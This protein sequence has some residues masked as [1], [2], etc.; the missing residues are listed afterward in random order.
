MKWLAAALAVVLV[1]LQYRLWVSEDGVRRWSAS[2]RRWPRSRP[3]TP[4]LAERNRQLAAEVR[5]LKTGMDALEERARSDLG[6]IARNE[7]FYQVV[8]AAPGRR[9]AADAD[10]GSLTRSAAAPAPWHR[11][12]SLRA[13]PMSIGSS[14]PPRAAAAASATAMPKQYAPLAGRTVIEWALAPFLADPR[15][16]RRRGGARGRIE[17]AAHRR[18]AGGA[19]LSRPRRR[20]ASAATRCAAGSPRST[21]ALQR[22]DWV[23]VHDAARPC[24]Q[25]A[26]LEQLLRRVADSRRR[27]PARGA[28][29]RHPQARR[30]PLRRAQAR[31]RTHASTGRSVAGADPADVP[32]RRAVRGARCSARAGRYAH[33]RGA[34]AR[35]ARRAAAAGRGLGRQ[36]QDHHARRTSRS[37]RGCSALAD[38]LAMRIGSG[39]DVHAFGPGDSDARRRA[40]PAQPRRRRAFGRRRGAARAVRC[41]A[42]RRRPRRHRPALSRHRPA[43]EGRRQPALRAPRARAAARARHLRVVNADLTVL[44]EAPR[45]APHRDAIRASIARLLEVPLERVNVKATTT[46]RLG[47]LGRAEG[48]AAQAIVLLSEALTVT[49]TAADAARAAALAPPR[50]YGAAAADAVLRERAEDFVVEE[51]LGFA[52]DGAG[53]HLL[54]RVRKSGANTPWVARE[55]ARRAGCR[56]QEVGS[57]ASRT[58]A[59]SPPS[60]SR[61]RGRGRRS[62]CGPCAA[63]V[64]RCWRRTR[65]TASSRAARSPETASPCAC[66]PPRVPARGSPSGSLRVLRPLPRTACRITSVPSASAATARISTRSPAT[67]R[68]C[69]P[70]SGGSCSRPRAASSS[71]RCSPR[72]SATAAGRGWSRGILRTSTAAAASSRFSHPMKRSRHAARASRSTPRGRCGGQG[73]PGR[74]PPCTRSRGG[75]G[76]VCGRVHAVCGGRHGPGAPEPAP[77]RGE[78]RCEAESGAVVLRFRLTRGSFATA[79]LRELVAAPGTVE[80]SE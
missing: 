61:S 4:Q 67:W 64:S 13:Q 41:A 33:R 23:L 15:C 8:P 46:E 26:D 52:P 72:A 69:R 76:G 22:D 78:L 73:S 7:T 21:A 40:H 28:R 38:E 35:V 14:C 9:A 18:A 74:A 53:A 80:G 59:R 50:A 66:A 47:F 16:A 63:R 11:S 24:L 37:P 55:L 60:G 20:R 25:P 3:R 71:T 19:R 34:G 36:H 10:R 45:V 5:D 29:R 39:L 54:L 1:L 68:A 42:R 30:T 31:G 56:P 44:A 17:L 51:D 6:M 2:G 62:T 49:A 58:G 75:R 79:V 57:P 70:P 43:L 27:R 77:A 65:T 12:R 32:L 48:I